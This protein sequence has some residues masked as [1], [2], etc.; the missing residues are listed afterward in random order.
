MN[1]S[2]RKTK[3][4]PDAIDVYVGHR[5][6]L[7]RLLLGMSREQ[8]SEVVGL[9]YQQIQKYEKGINRISAGRLYTFSRV[10]NVSIPYFYDGMNDEGEAIDPVSFAKTHRESNAAD[11]G[12][13]EILPIV[14]SIKSSDLRHE[15]LSFAKRMKKIDEKR[16]SGE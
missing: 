6:K 1:A 7:R 13:I 9:T 2:L 14:A 5:L 4:R 16:S 11:G 3:G 15:V 10:L 8:L 12:T